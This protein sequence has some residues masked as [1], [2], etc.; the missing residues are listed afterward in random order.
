MRNIFSNKDYIDDFTVRMA[1]HSTAIEGNSLTQD[2]TASII[3]NG[4]IP[5][6][7]NEKEYYEVKNYKNSIPFL[8][9]CLENNQ[10]IDNELIKQIHTQ[11]MANLIY[12]QFKT[13]QNMIIGAT[14]DTE[15][16]YK[17]PYILKD[18][19]DNL[20]LALTNAKNEEKLKIILEQHIKFEKAHPFSD[21]NGRVGRFLIL[22]STLQENLIPFVI[23]KQMKDEYIHAL[24]NH[25]IKAL[26]DL[27]KLAQEIELKIMQKID[28]N[29]NKE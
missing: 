17:I 6:K 22:Y 27:A 15:L 2:E 29:T 9:K 5:K 23:D 12:N 20:N 19:C 7:M 25:D 11:L 4:I 8:L 14:F 13:T 26:C 1:H 21:G 18:W 10:F 28:I 3:L 16:P 24:R